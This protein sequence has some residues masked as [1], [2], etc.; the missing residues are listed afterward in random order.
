[1]CRFLFQ[2]KIT[3][4]AFCSNQKKSMG[5]SLRSQ[6]YPTLYDPLKTPVTEDVLLI[7]LIFAF[8][9][10]AASFIVIIP[11]IRGWEVSNL[12]S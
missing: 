3:C 8:A 9:I 1:M 2:H 11:G 12:V 6:P 4:N 7:G 5:N 10:I